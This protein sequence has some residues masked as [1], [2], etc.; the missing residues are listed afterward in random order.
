MHDKICFTQKEL[1][2]RWTLS[3]RTL[4]R[5]R[6]EGKGPAFMKIGGRVVYRLEDILNHEKEQLQLSNCIRTPRVS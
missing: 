6:W 1:A 3:H 2:R 4:E 5:W